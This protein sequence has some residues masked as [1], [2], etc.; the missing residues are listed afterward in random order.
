MVFFRFPP[1]I[2]LSFMHCDTTERLLK[3]AINTLT[4]QYNKVYLSFFIDFPPTQDSSLLPNIQS[5][6][7][8]Q[9]KYNYGHGGYPN[10]ATTTVDM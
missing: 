1:P 7:M 9:S 6:S 3:V 2:K 10:I 4:L 8:S 5:K